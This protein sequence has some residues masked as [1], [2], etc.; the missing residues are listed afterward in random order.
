SN[1][2]RWPDY[3]MAGAISRAGTNSPAYFPSVGGLPRKR[4]YANC[5]ARICQS[6]AALTRIQGRPQHRLGDGLPHGHLGTPGGWRALTHA[7][8]YIAAELHVAEPL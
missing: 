6:G 7:A 5:H 4:N 1:R 3:G 2:P 8:D